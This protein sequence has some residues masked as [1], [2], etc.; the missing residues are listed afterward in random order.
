MLALRRTRACID[1]G[2]V[3][4]QVQFDAPALLHHGGHGETVRTTLEDCCR[5]RVV[6]V[7]AVNPR[8]SAES[9][10]VG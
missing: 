5:V 3:P 4:T 1:C 8:T 7:E 6:S 10:P 9:A 2:I